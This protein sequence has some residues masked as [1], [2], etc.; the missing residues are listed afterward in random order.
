[1]P[2]EGAL[3]PAFTGQLM[4]DEQ[5]ERTLFEA[6]CNQLGSYGYFAFGD[7]DIPDYRN[8]RNFIGRLFAGSRDSYGDIF[9]EIASV[10]RSQSSGRASTMSEWLS[11]W[12][13]AFR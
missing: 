8:I 12:N 7:R 4:I 10:R 1:M 3:D 13:L 9:T 6:V 5:F 11:N 2:E